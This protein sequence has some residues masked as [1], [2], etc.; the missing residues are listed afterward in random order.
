M[1]KVFV[2]WA[3]LLLSGCMLPP[4]PSE[5]VADAAR[6]LNLATRF[7]RMDLAMSRTAK[8][9]QPVFMKHRASWGGELRIVDLELV[10]LNMPDESSAIVEVEVSWVRMQDGTLRSTRV[11]QVWRDQGGGWLL[12]RE[13]RTSGDLG[14]FGE[15][16]RFVNQPARDVQ[17]ATKTIR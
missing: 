14:L 15:P 9:L 10:G 8:A 12:T 7:G 6:E 3:V 4:P 1:R 13:K 17:F 16:V 11:A 2:V 5:R